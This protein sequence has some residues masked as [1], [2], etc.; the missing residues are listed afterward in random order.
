MPTAPRT[1]RAALRRLAE[2]H[3]VQTSFIDGGGVRRSAAD[4]DLVLV[5]RALG[6]P[7]SRVSEASRLGKQREQ[8]LASRCLDPITVAWADD[9][10]PAAYL[11]IPPRGLPGKLSCSLTLEDGSSA[12]FMVAT[13]DLRT[14][15]RP[16]PE[17]GRAAFAAVPLPADLP[18][19]YHTL[20]LSFARR[21]HSTRIFAAPATSYIPP[22]VEAGGEDAR[23]WGVFCPLYALRS[24]RNLGVGDLTDLRRLADW[25]ASLGGRVVAT[26]PML[27]CFLGDSRG[28]GLVHDPS[29]YSPASRLFWNE[30]FTDPTA[31]EEFPL[32]AEAR[33]A[34][35]SA[36]SRGELQSLR[37]SPLVDYARA[38]P[39][40]RRILDR[41][42]AFF[43]ESGRDRSPEFQAFLKERP[44]AELYA[45]FRAVGERL[46]TPWPEWP[47]R[48]R[49]G[50]IRPGEFDRAARDA[51]LYSQ[52]LFHRQITA[53]S[54]SLRAKGGVLYLDLPVGVH[55]FSFDVWRDPALFADGASTGA[56][57]DPY[58]TG[59]QNWG[60]PPMHP[61]RARDTHYAHLIDVLRNHFR[62]A[63]YLRLDHV[64]AF[65]RL[66]WIPSHRTADHG[67]YVS[68]N[69]D[70]HYAVLAIESQRA[71]CR[72]IGENLGTVPPEVNERLH[73][74]RVGALYVAQYEIQPDPKHC[75][76]QPPSNAAASINTHDMAPFATFL[77]GGD[78]D[79]RIG[80]KM[81]D[82]AKR[83]AEVRARD[84]VRESL[85]RF[86][87]SRRL[88]AAR[89]TPAQTRDGVLDFLASS[90]AELM[91]VNLEDAWLETKWQNVPGT[92]HEHANWQRK[93]RL[94]LEELETTAALRS[95][96]TRVAKL[97][98]AGPAPGPS[99]APR[100]KAAR[101]PGKAGHTRPRR[102][103]PR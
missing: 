103:L 47:A 74:R 61:E 17:G 58:F 59:G 6:S 13:A 97:R 71:R 14:V 48:L 96:L 4:E 10:S 46:D 62:Y 63:D 100:A 50:T 3:G 44:L 99:A 25:S 93:L 80:L 11:R 51:H 92:L 20:E 32:C 26:L 73:R 12:D 79:D 30:L 89:P 18:R 91:L 83:P 39:F 43:F 95:L 54:R 87:A 56:P 76:R 2:L 90:D 37:T 86:L 60:F 72:L 16:A 28:P 55:P 5:L 66:F 57:P 70:E 84:A 9:R 1:A 29:P 35:D 101:K 23:R 81:L 22:E 45:Q 8:L 24:R 31:A 78:I 52:F 40:K 42:A 65:D 41:L 85:R 21:T 67:V 64:M 88:A 82:A 49:G 33:A 68:Y 69:P 7:I 77:A 102:S 94:A 38:M 34:A 36:D 15:K 98:R 75:L 27:A 19:G 53:L